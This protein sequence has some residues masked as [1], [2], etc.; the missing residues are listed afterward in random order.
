MTCPTE[1]YRRSAKI[2][3]FRPPGECNRDSST[4][5]C[6]K[7]VLFCASLQNKDALSFRKTEELRT[8]LKQRMAEE[9]GNGAQV[10]SQQN[11][12][13][14]SRTAGTKAAQAQVP[15]A[16]QHDHSKVQTCSTTLLL[17]HA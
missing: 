12:A 3:D 16:I 9:L 11:A 6:D 8:R 4:D 17:S 10:S 2:K 15:A 5:H 7:A 13:V 14:S 1:V